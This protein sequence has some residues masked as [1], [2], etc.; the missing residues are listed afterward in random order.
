MSD[1]AFATEKELIDELARRSLAI[2]VIATRPIKVGNGDNDTYIDYRG[3]MVSAVGLVNYAR[4]VLDADVVASVKRASP[5]DD[6]DPPDEN[7][8][9]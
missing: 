4:A 8:D 6:P 9:A 3:G 7:T 2:V 5:E 1:L